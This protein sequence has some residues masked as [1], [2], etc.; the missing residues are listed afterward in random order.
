[1]EKG[2]KRPTNERDCS[3]YQ[4]RACDFRLLHEVRM[5]GIEGG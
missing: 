5:R 4:G 2:E 1:M 3:M